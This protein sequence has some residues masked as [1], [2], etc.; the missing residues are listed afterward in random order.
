MVHQW[1]PPTGM[2]YDLDR[3]IFC[4]L[5]LTFSHFQATNGGFGALHHDDRQAPEGNETTTNY[6]TTITTTTTTLPTVATTVPQEAWSELAVQI[7]QH[8][9][10]PKSRKIV[11]LCETNIYTLY[12][13]SAEAQLVISDESSGVV[14]GGKVSPT[15]DQ[16]SSTSKGDPDNSAL[17]ASAVSAYDFSLRYL[18]VRQA[19]PWLLL[20]LV[21]V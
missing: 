20:L 12:R 3:G 13:G 15:T 21:Y 5:P 1:Q 11:I 6:T 19:V 16:R 10:R 2:H 18:L 14:A 9:L 8:V 7:D 4:W 17:Q